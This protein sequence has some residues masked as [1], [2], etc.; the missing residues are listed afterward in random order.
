MSIQR[1]TLRDKYM[2]RYQAG[3]GEADDDGEYVTYADHVAA[4]LTQ[5]MQHGEQSHAHYMDG[6]NAALDAARDAVAALGGEPSVSLD[7]IDCNYSCDDGACTCSGVR[8]VR[9]WTL[10]PA[11][12]LAA[13]DG[14]R[15]DAST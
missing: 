1:W 13:I 11:D 12:A 2:D 15:P 6:Y 5:D 7:P 8:R 3:E 9:A 4:L 10:N 14:L